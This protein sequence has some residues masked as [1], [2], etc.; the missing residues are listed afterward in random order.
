MNAMKTK[1]AEPIKLT[2][3]ERM[4][5][6]RAYNST[7][8]HEMTRAEMVDHIIAAINEERLEGQ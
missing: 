8:K 7:T 2:D 1:V 3:M 5:A 4:A 6:I